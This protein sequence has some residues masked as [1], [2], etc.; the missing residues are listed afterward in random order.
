MED[1]KSWPC[2]R[3]PCFPGERFGPLKLFVMSTPPPDPAA[4]AAAQKALKEFSIEA[5]TLLGIGIMVTLLRTYARVKFVGFKN[6]Q[7]DDYL[8][9]VGVVSYSATQ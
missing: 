7:P 4:L 8:V 9:W 3:L 2:A 1:K 6:L 5:W